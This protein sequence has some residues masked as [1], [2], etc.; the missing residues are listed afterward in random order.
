MGKMMFGNDETLT[1][2]Q[3]V[4]VR[5]PQ[6]EA[7]CLA[8]KTTKLF[9]V[10]GIYLRD[11]GYVLRLETDTTKY[12]PLTQERIDEL[13]QAA[14]L[15][16]PLPAYSIP[17]FEYAFGY[18]LWLVVAGCVVAWAIGNARKKRRQAEDAAT[19]TSFGPPEIKTKVDRFVDEQVRAVLE[20][21]EVV[22]HQ[23]YTLDREPQGGLGDA[24]ASACYAVLTDRRLLLFKTRVGAFGP[25]LENKGTEILDRA[26]VGRVLVDDRTIVIELDDGSVRTLWVSPTTKLSNQRAFLRDVPRILGGDA[27]ERAW[28]QAETAAS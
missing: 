27:P 20:H 12:F 11:D 24:R 9:F 26:R 14:L 25:L 4:D 5:G 7:L 21:G 13:Q 6:G 28:A 8:Y 10:A 2:I 18:S 22:H 1:C 19:P 15:P 16:R 3:H 17:W 23:A